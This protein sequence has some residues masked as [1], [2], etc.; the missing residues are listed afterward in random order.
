MEYFDTSL[1]LWF[2]K[3]AGQSPAYDFGI[4][5]FADYLAYILVLVFITWLIAI[6]INR[7]KVL[8]TAVATILVGRVFL[9]EIIRFFYHSPRPFVALADA[10][11]LL[12]KS[13]YSFPSGHAT[14]FFGLSAVIYFYDKKLGI[15]FFV[16]SAIMGLA[17][18]M[19]GVHY[20]L[21]IL[22]GVILGTVVGFACYKLT[23][24]FFQFREKEN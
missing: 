6:K 20:P 15:T 11:Q 24:I 22:G 21:D 4:V 14:F 13:G 16:L 17:R 10:T 5:F 12:P 8:S 7:I 1:F 18:I 2:N 19:A 23:N 3:F 9:V